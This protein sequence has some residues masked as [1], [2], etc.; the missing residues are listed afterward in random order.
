MGHHGHHIQ[1]PTAS[2]SATL[3]CLEFTVIESF[4]SPPRC[5]DPGGAEWTRFHSRP[6]GR[7]LMLIISVGI[8]ELS[9]LPESNRG[10]DPAPPLNAVAAC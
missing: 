5:L 9:V 10:F 2:T 3:I 8:S 7:E 4:R 6:P 1:Q